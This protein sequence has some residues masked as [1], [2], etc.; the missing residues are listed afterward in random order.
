MKQ[1]GAACVNGTDARVSAPAALSFTADDSKLIAVGGKDNT[2]LLW[3][4]M[5]SM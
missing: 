5:R 4:V 3:S 2:V 1:E